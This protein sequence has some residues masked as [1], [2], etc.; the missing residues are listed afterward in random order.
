MRSRALRL[1]CGALAWLA[2]GAAAVFIVRSE[3]HITQLTVTVRAFDLHAREGA[4]ALADLRNAQQAYVS[5]GQGVAFWMQKVATTVDTARN[6]IA[7]LRGS[8]TSPA[9]LSELMEA[10]ATVAEF[11]AVDKRARDYIKTGDQLM[12]ADVIFAEGGETA[13]AAGR[14]VE[15]ARLAEQQALDALEAT[16][17]RRQ[18]WAAAAAGGFAAFIVLLLVPVRRTVPIEEAGAAEPLPRAITIAPPPEA[19]AAPPQAALLKTAAELSTDFGRVRDLADL[20]RLLARVAEL[21]DASG[22]V[23]W[24]G[25]TNGGDLQPIISHGYTPHVAARMPAVPRNADNAAAAAYRT[26]VMQIVLKR[27]GG[28]SGAIVAPILSADGCIGAFSAETR[29][30][31]EGSDTVQAIAAIVAAHL[32]SVFLATADASDTQV[33]SSQ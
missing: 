15:A 21:V 10:E 25:N 18:A 11:D 30:G 6:T 2:L 33:A 9:A 31:A 17:R 20:K 28:P 29:S 32:A 3:H 19:P 24:L 26:G 22:L 16:V 27:P 8:A 13:A 4:D 12:A 14:H 5:A 7:T 1:I 23:V